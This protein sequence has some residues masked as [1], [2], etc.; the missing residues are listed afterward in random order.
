M[1][2]EFANTPPRLCRTNLKLYDAAIVLNGQ[3]V[4]QA[5]IGPCTDG[6]DQE[7]EPQE[8]DVVV[9]AFKTAGKTLYL[10]AK[11]RLLGSTLSRSTGE[12]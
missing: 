10:R 2:G 3:A 4:G 7:R 11:L 8:G 5:K 12:T 9:M 6:R 1:A